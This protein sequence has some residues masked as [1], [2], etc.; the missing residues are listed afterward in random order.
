VKDVDE[1]LDDIT[2]EDGNFI[3]PSVTAGQAAVDAF[4]RGEDP[5]STLA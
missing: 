3:D 2:D 1:I 5:A 4:R